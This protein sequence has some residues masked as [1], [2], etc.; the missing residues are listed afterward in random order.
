MRICPL[1]RPSVLVQ[2]GIELLTGTKTGF[3]FKGIIRLSTRME[4]GVVQTFWE[5]YNGSPLYIRKA[6]TTPIPAP[7]LSNS[8]KHPLNPRILDG[9]Q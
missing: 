3:G 1:S 6:F 8:G 7:C 2:V 9:V 5:T 4:T